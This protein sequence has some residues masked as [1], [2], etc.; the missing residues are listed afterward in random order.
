MMMQC[1]RWAGLE[2]LQQVVELPVDVAT[3]LRVT[4]SMDIQLKHEDE[5]GA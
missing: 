5:C 2:E 4:C 3:Y 1:M